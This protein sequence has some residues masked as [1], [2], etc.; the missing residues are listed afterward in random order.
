MTPDIER[1]VDALRERY[2]TYGQSGH[3]RTAPMSEALSTALTIAVLEALA[4]PSDAA[5]EPAAEA[6]YR[7][8]SVGCNPEWTWQFAIEHNF[9]DVVECRTEARAAGR[10]M[11]LAELGRMK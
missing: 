5:V 2:R 7:V 8:Q 1:A 10:A 6:L 3:L 11:R 9:S 4:E